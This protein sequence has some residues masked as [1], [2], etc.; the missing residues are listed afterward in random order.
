MGIDTGLAIGQ[1][2]DEFV[3]SI[4]TDIVQN[5]VVIPVCDHYFCDS[6]IRPWVQS[7]ANC[8]IDR[9]PVEEAA[10]TKPC[11]YFRNKLARVHFHCQFTD[12]NSETTYDGFEVH[13]NSCRYNPDAWMDCTFCHVKHKIIEEATHKNSCLP[14]LRDKIAKN[15]LEKKAELKRQREADK[16]QYKAELEYKRPRTSLYILSWN[17]KLPTARAHHFANDSYYGT[18]S[19]FTGNKVGNR[20][21]KSHPKF[22]L[23]HGQMQVGLMLKKDTEY[24]DISYVT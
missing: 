8:P 19:H 9:D 12:C 11:R 2:D 22:K 4:C 5:P 1:F 6:C 21:L 14:F 15:E 17:A 23:N 24:R 7:K 10:L 18:V 20:A 3:C 16:N 13:K